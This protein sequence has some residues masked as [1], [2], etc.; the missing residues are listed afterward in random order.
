MSELNEHSLYCLPCINNEPV[1][2]NA[3]F[4]C[5][6]VASFINSLPMGKA[7]GV[8]GINNEM[9]KHS[10]PYIV[11]YLTCLYNNILDTGNLPHAWG[12]AIINPILK[13]GNIHDP[14]NYRGISLLSSVSLY[15]Y[16]K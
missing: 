15:R 14:N 2:L 9:L 5:C 6:E 8:D 12:K 11:N 4:S 7:A 13:K 1:D 16:F 10:C 3:P